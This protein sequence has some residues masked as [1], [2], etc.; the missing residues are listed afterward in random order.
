M[1][2]AHHVA[3]AQRALEEADDQ[4]LSDLGVVALHGGSSGDGEAATDTHRTAFDLAFN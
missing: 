4:G 3:G 1:V 2:D